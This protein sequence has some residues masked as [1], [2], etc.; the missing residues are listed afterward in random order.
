[1]WKAVAQWCSVNIRSKKLLNVGKHLC[2]SL[3]FNKVS[4]VYL[5]FKFYYKWSLIKWL[6]VRK[7]LGKVIAKHLWWSSL[8]LKL[9]TVTLQ[10]NIFSS[11]FWIFMRFYQ[12]SESNCSAS[13]I[14]LR[15][16]PCQGNNNLAYQTN[17]HPFQSVVQSC[18]VNCLA[19]K[20]RNTQRKMSTVVIKL[21]G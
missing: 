2:G 8:S 17:V 14:R 18:F 1:M 15:Q 11:E 4:H 16:L 9:E 13:P 6:A 12:Y 21:Q 19:E 5:H 20:S 7:K 3:F 10:R